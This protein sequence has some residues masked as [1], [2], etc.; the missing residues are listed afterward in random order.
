MKLKDSEIK[1]GMNPNTEDFENWLKQEL[2]QKGGKQKLLH[3]VIWIIMLIFGLVNMIAGGIL[4]LTFLDI[5]L[6]WNENLLILF[7]AMFYGGIFFTTL[8]AGFPGIIKINHR[9]RQANIPKY[10]YQQF[11][12][13]CYDK[14]VPLTF[15]GIDDLNN[16]LVFSTPENHQITWNVYQTNKE[17]KWANMPETNADGSSINWVD[18]RPDDTTHKSHFQLHSELTVETVAFKNEVGIKLIRINAPSKNLNQQN[19]FLT[20]SMEFNQKYQ[21]VYPEG[22]EQRVARL[23]KPKLVQT[24]VE[25]NDYCPHNN[26]CL[27]FADESIVMKWDSLILPKNQADQCTNNFSEMKLTKKNEVNKLT[28]KVQKD[29]TWFFANLSLLEPFEI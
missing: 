1:T 16:N 5:G 18:N 22:S 17:F 11:W 7:L 12:K 15:E 13:L 28:E 29:F 26:E 24:F 21:I 10:I 25:L 19:I 6:H 8:G 23:F 3:P 14:K 20:P 4:L 27:E 9:R 2:E